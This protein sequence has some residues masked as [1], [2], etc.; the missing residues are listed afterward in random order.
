MPPA[1]PW[2]GSLR[3][4]RPGSSVAVPLPGES[5]ALMQDA[6]IHIGSGAS[7]FQS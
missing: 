4:W 3:V 6:Q 7:P 5:A 2:H 1:R